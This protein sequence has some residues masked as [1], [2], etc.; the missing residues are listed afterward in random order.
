MF[1]SRSSPQL[2]HPRLIR[3]SLAFSLLAVALALFIGPILTHAHSPARPLSS[4]LGT[5]YLQQAEDKL[6]VNQIDGRGW[7]E[8]GLNI[9][10]TG[11]DGNA[12]PGLE[13]S[14]FEIREENQPQAV[15]GL[16][17]GPARSIPLALVLVMDV[18]GSMA[19]E[20]LV[21][22]K[23]AALAFLSSLRPEDSAALL[24]FSSFVRVVV[25]STSDRAALEL[26]L[27]ALQPEGNTA[28]YDALQRSA[29]LVSQAPPGMRRAIVLLSDGA[30]TSSRF[31]SAVA[32]EAARRSNALVYTIGLGADANDAILTS[33]SAPSGGLYYKAPAPEDLKGVYDA[34]S[35]QLSSQLILK[36]NSTTQ[37]ERSYKLI[38]VQVKYTSK[39]GQVLVK[40]LRYRPPLAA[41]RP[42]TPETSIAP[43]PF[44][45]PVIPTP[46]P[47]TAPSQSNG[48]PRNL[49]LPGNVNAWGALGAVFTATAIFLFSLFAAERFSPSKASQRLERYTGQVPTAVAE[50]GENSPGFTSRILV[51]MLQGLGRRI[52]RLT[53]KAYVEHIQQLL[54][55]SGPPYRLQFAEV[56]GMQFGLSIILTVPLV[57]WAVRT[58]PNTPMQWV[59]IGAFTLILGAYLPY[60]MLSS[61]VRK[62]Q[63]RLLR[64]LPGA[65]DFLAINVEAGMGFDAALTEVVQRWH[66]PLTDEF[67]L[68]L[69]D[70]QIGKP[71][72]DAWRDLIQ[73]T[74]LPD[75]TTFVTSMMQNEQVGSSI[76]GLL[77]T[78][79]EYMR[80]KRR[81]RAETA[82]RVAPVKMLLPLVFFVF[83]GILVVLLG[84]AIPQILQAFGV[85]GR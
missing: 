82:A 56:V 26:G 44:S 41:L 60:F 61:R 10:L 13:A 46:A 73:R 12:V 22:A 18:S 32:A 35:L 39:S 15:A 5:Q 23:A 78:Q 11:P 54:L 33:L 14:Q 1:I 76:G 81:Q 83:P 27:N 2:P 47:V 84:P 59:L 19:G 65:L 58:L 80:I 64:A 75:L 9:S 36:Y 8:I 63:S 68:L 51:P 49:S 72:R 45:Q 69:I 43:T 55:L 4:L 17:L 6:V 50:T 20:K 30:D 53:P 37:V 24:A 42:S 71:R 3:W 70:F 74:Q 67:A 38:S 34:I 85:V 7:P 77:R 21:Q 52:T 48:P 25:P 31:S 79:A 29:E 57:W 16:T 66:N 62:R 40:S 28:L